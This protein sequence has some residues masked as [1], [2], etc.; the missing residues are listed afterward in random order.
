[1][2]AIGNYYAYVDVAYNAN[3]PNNGF[4]STDGWFV[5]NTVVLGGGSFSYFGYGYPSDCFL[6]GK[7]KQLASA[8]YGNAVHSNSVLRVPCLN[9]SAP[10]KGCTQSCT[11]AQW[12]VRGYDHGT[13]VGPL[14]QNE[15]I[16]AA[17]ELL[18]G[19]HTTRHKSDDG[20][21]QYH[22]HQHHLSFSLV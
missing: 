11:L 3:G 12:L 17:G 15:E 21:N 22:H 9:T 16:I 5:N 19:I 2:R 13:T 14:P 20:D 18:L 7:S 1:M 10:A 8:I 4:A 6:V